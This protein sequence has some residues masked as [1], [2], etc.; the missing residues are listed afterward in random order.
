MQQK[1]SSE[2][3]ELCDEIIGKC[4]T[5]IEENPR[6]EEFATSVLTKVESMKE[7]IESSGRVSDKQITSLENMDGGIS[8]WIRE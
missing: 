6:G 7:F 1:T 4:E 8:K 5:V 3:I 2:A